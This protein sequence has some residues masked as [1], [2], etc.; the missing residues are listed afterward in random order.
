MGELNLDVL[1]SF[2]G[3]LI[4]AYRVFHGKSTTLRYD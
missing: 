4:I 2:L 3:W 1:A